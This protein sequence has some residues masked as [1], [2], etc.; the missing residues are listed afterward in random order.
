MIRGIRT[1]P[2]DV[3]ADVL[4]CVATV[5]MSGGAGAVASRKP[6]L[7]MDAC[8]YPVRINSTVERGCRAG[9]ISCRISSDN[10]RLGGR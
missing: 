9:Y 4:C 3:R 5:A 7:K 6:V 1:K 10:G 8:D 2:A